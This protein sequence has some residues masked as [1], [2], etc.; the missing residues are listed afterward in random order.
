MPTAFRNKQ[1]TSS[2]NIKIKCVNVHNDDM[3]GSDTGNTANNLLPCS[4]VLIKV[5]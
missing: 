2:V 4:E 3:N 1:N 5:F